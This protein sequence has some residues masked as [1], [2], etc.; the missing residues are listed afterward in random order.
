MTRRPVRCVVC[1][2]DLKDRECLV[3]G[4][5]GRMIHACPPAVEAAYE[6]AQ[7]RA[8]RGD[9]FYGPCYAQKLDDGF[10][11]LGLADGQS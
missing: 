5:F 2:R 11:L 7:T 1:D 6:A 8:E 3:P 10:W 9:E 4:L